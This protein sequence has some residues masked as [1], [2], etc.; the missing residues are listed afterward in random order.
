MKFI[1]KNLSTIILLLVFCTGVCLLLYPTVSD[2]WNSFHQTRVITT[3]METVADMDDGTYEELLS[4]AQAYNAELAETGVKWEMSEEELA[5]YDSLLNIGEQGLMGYIEI[6]SI[7]CKLPI[8]HGTADQVLQTGVG[9][10]EGTSLPVGGE[11][12]HAVISGH[13]GLPSAKLF[14]NLDRLVEGD[15]FILNILDEM[16]TYE[17]DKILIVEPD[18]LSALTIEPG[19][20]YCTLVT[21]TPYGINTHRLLVRGHRVPNEGAVRVEA[22]AL[23][24]DKV[25]VASVIAVP[26]LLLLLIYLLVRTR[27][28]STRKGKRK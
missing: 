10:L 12:T 9:H 21:C 4:A 7:N 24:L 20:D 23:Q 28:T 15:T 27:R 14:T 19:Q 22:D 17:V 1:R 26:I 5:T 2:Y 8:Y 3:Y 13:R 11:S 16:L 6:S 18:D 25:I